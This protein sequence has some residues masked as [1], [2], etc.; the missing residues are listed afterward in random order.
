MI[1]SGTINLNSIQRLQGGV[2]TYHFI[3][4]S[5][6]KK[7]GKRK[8]MAQVMLQK[9]MMSEICQTVRRKEDYT[10]GAEGL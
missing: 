3:G 2:R 10:L 4:G 5:S 8:K 1:N 7:L 6:C 9:S